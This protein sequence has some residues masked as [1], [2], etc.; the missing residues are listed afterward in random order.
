MEREE[1]GRLLG[2]SCL[3]WWR[4]RTPSQARPALT[5]LGV[6][7]RSTPPSTNGRCGSECCTPTHYWSLTCRAACAK[8]LAAAS[9]CCS[10]AARGE[11]PTVARQPKERGGAEDQKRRT[12]RGVQKGQ[13][14]DKGGRPVG[15]AASTRATAATLTSSPAVSLK[16]RQIIAPH[17]ALPFACPT[18]HA[19]TS[20]QAGTG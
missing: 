13:A 5:I 20:P 2:C 19:K 11:T 18:V 14:R 3:G 6:G 15:P 16:H 17:A 12:T 4:T 7:A 9:L 1:I 8:R 10:S